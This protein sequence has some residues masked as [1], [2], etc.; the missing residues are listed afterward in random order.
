MG[1]WTDFDLLNSADTV[2]NTQDFTLRDFMAEKFWGHVLHMQV[3]V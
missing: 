3:D 1:N 2:H